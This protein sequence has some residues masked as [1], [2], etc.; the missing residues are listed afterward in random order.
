MTFSSW[1]HN[2]VGSV[3]AA[4]TTLSFV[5][6]LLKVWNSKSARDISL[7]MF[8]L[9]SFGEALWLLYGILIR[10]VPVIAANAVTLLLCL[11]ILWLKL[12]YR[13]LESPAK[14]QEAEP[15][16]SHEIEVEV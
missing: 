13:N 16:K 12:R 15:A 10:S 4:C 1:L 9:L 5:P 3:A 6:Q 11:I 2:S 7:N 14:S 8:L